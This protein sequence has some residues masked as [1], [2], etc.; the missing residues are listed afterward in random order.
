MQ[1][2]D[3]E[4]RKRESRFNL[5][6]SDRGKCE[7]E[8]VER[9]KKIDLELSFADSSICKPCFREIGQLEKHIPIYK[10]WRNRIN[11]EINQK[12]VHEKR[13]ISPSLKLV[14]PSL[15]HRKKQRILADVN[16]GLGGARPKTREI[17]G[18]LSERL[19]PNVE[20]L[21]FSV[22]EETVSVLHLS[23][24]FLP[25]SVNEKNATL[26]VVGK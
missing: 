12:S 11:S 25:L 6:T 4:Y 24:I 13:G 17:R 1:I 2:A 8:I 9:L 20:N 21:A 7:F 15:L 3:Y 23:Q 18:S 19:Y 22:S 16:T 5:Y 10:S 26:N 14:T